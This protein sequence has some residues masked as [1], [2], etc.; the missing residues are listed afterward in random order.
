ME[1]VYIEQPQ[2]FENFYFPNHIFRLKKALYSLKQAPRAWYNILKSSLI[3]NIDDIIFGATDKSLWKEFVQFMQDEF[4]MSMMG[5]L[6][7]FLQLQIKQTKYDIFINQ[8]KYI[9]D[10][11]KRF[12]MEYVKET[13]TPMWTSTKLD[14]DKNDKNVDI[15]KHQDMI[16]PLLHLIANRPNI[17]FCVY[18]FVRCQACPKQSHVSDVKW[19]LYLHGTI[20]LG[21]WYLKGNELSLISY[22]DADFTECKVNRKSTSGTCRFLRSSLVSW[23]IKKQN[24][25]ALQQLKRNIQRQVVV[26]YKA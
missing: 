17:M 11:L 2:D 18:L 1:K 5:E 6:N 23:A 10:L 21:L 14:M 7:L 3:E 8:S 15:T 22:S 12:G 16:G 4:E 24:L 25:V 26:V 20:N 13:D 19:I 9:K